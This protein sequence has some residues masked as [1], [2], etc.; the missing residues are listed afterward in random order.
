MKA[1]D[2]A[3][4]A[5]FVTNFIWM[6]GGLYLLLK[7]SG[8]AEITKIDLMKSI[9]YNTDAV[10]TLKE[11]AKIFIDE[12]ENPSEK[13]SV[14]AVGDL[15]LKINEL[16]ELVEALNQKPVEA[17]PAA[18]PQVAQKLREKLKEVLIKNSQMQTEL[19]QVKYRLKKASDA[20]NDV[21]DGFSSIKGV[22]PEFVKMMVGRT[23]ALEEDLRA[24]SERAESAESIA[25]SQKSQ[26]ED[27]EEKAESAISLAANQARQIEEL[28]ARAEKNDFVKAAAES[29]AVKNLKDEKDTMEK[30]LKTE[31]EIMQTTLIGRIQHLETELDRVITEKQFI[32]ERYLKLLEEE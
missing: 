23:N 25:S 8:T 32:E 27:L 15:T 20:N 21:K 11:A 31:K 16:Y 9:G 29:L 24:A 18:D 13:A 3:F 30:L 26:L 1:I 22:D 28:R 4:M 5:V 6:A 10:G 17:E 12:S 7:I 2:W 19:D 14:R